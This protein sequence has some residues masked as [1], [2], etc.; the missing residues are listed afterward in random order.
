[1]KFLKKY[2]WKIAWLALWTL[3]IFYFIPRQ[4][5]FYLRSDKDNFSDASHRFLVFFE[6]AALSFLI[7]WLSLKVE[8]TGMLRRAWAVL[9]STL[10]ATFYL[11]LFYL[12]FHDAAT[13]IGLF[14]N[15]QTSHGVVRRAYVAEYFNGDE[16]KAS[17]LHLYDI[18]AKSLQIDDTLSKSAYRIRPNIG[19]TLQVDLKKGLF[20]I[21]Y[22]DSLTFRK[23]LPGQ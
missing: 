19:D 20:N 4:D 11:A 2:K 8:A 22:F 3:I 18:G 10:I 5:E 1:M 23:K 12:F 17:N 7:V 21:P 6:A 9:Q 14:I 16:T 13:A 15:R